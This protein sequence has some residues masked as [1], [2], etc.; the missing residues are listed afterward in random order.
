V[1]AASEAHNFY[2]RRTDTHRFTWISKDGLTRKEI[3]HV[4]VNSKWKAIQNCRV[5][6]RFEFNTDHSVVIATLGLRL[7]NS[8]VQ[9]KQTLRCDVRKI[10]DPRIAHCCAIY[11]ENQFSVLSDLQAPDWTTFRD[12]TLNATVNLLGAIKRNNI[13]WISDKSLDIIES[14]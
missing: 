10:R 14:T 11:I 8:R 2:L 12:V 3:D 13:A 1:C 5:Y 7:K 4:L 6:R 9:C